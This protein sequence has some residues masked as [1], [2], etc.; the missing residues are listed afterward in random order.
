MGS[1]EMWTRF[2]LVMAQVSARGPSSPRR[3]A[4]LDR[5]PWR[6]Q[7]GR[8][9]DCTPSSSAL[10]SAPSRPRP[11]PV[12]GPAVLPGRNRRPS[13]SDASPTRDPG[14]V[15]AIA[16]YHALDD[17]L[18]DD[19]STGERE[20]HVV[21]RRLAHLDVV[22]Q[23]PR[24]IQGPHHGGRQPGR[25][26]HARPTHAGR[27]RTRGRPGTSGATAPHRGSASESASVTSRCALR[28]ASFSSR[29][30]PS[31]ITRPWS[32]TTIRC[33][34]ASASSRYCVVNNTVTPSSS[35][36]RIASHTRWRLVGSS[37]VVGSSKNRTG[38]RVINDAARSSRRRIPPE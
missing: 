38:G 23:H 36:S 18:F 31:A 7:C 20:E 33:A 19:V 14:P 4:T 3:T 5:N 37:P 8:G 2:R 28:L 16:I 12:D 1:R 13:P 15:T 10:A 34:N 32:T 35:S 29:G 30:V 24:G 9:H 22:H 17:L 21:E 6:R 25:R 11:A 27:R 26:V